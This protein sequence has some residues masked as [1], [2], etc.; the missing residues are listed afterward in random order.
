MVEKDLEIGAMSQVAS[1]LA[2]LDDGARARVLEW[3]LK[4]YDVKLR[5][6]RGASGGGGNGGRGSVG[7]GFISQEFDVFADLFDAASPKTET[8]RALV[9][10]YWFQV[11][12]GSADF[13]G[14]AV[15]DALKDVG[16]GVS[17]ITN[18][19]SKLQ[20]RKPALVRQ[21]AKSGRSQ[22]ARKKYKLT[23]AGI[24]AVQKMMRGGGD[25]EGDGE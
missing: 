20:N 18:A 1:A 11:V 16:H 15:N 4:R 22:Q 12:Q 10:G 17:N 25:D 13:G 3:A 8:D 14:Q 6:A 23:T 7:D 5:P 21:V 19:L 2:D 9:G 24:S